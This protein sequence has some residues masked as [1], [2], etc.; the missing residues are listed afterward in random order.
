MIQIA[1]LSGIPEAKRRQA[2]ECL[3]DL[4]TFKDL[5][6]ILSPIITGY[7][8]Y[9]ILPNF[10]SVIAFSNIHGTETYKQDMLIDLVKL[11]Y[12]PKVILSY[13]REKAGV[14]LWELYFEIRDEKGIILPGLKIK[15][16]RT[17]Q[18]TNLELFTKPLEK[19][20]QFSSSEGYLLGE[21]QGWE[22]DMPFYNKEESIVLLDLFLKK[23]GK[24]IHDEEGGII[25]E[26]DEERELRSPWTDAYE[27]PVLLLGETALRYADKLPHFAL[28]TKIALKENSNEISF[29]I[30]KNLK[31]LRDLSHYEQLLHLGFCEE[32]CLGNKPFIARYVDKKRQ[33]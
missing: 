32:L 22:L 10:D 5:Q 2:I 33:V 12:A 27:T 6:G 7:N 25:P 24:H 21:D 4:L 30:H 14:Y 8:L 1:D 13:I 18:H 19:Y 11:G 17:K 23:S 28:A 31:Q 29:V 20:E 16:V 3:D 9:T 26:T 15:D